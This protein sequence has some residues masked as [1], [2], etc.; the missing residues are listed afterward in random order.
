MTV[1]EH[2]L[3]EDLDLIVELLPL[4]LMMRAWEQYIEWYYQEDNA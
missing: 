1:E 4:D 3:A 2:N